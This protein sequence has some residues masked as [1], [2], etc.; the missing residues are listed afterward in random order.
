MGKNLDN[1][2]KIILIVVLVAVVGVLVY[3]S[4]SNYINP[5]LTVSQVKNGQNSYQGKVVQV[6]GIVS[7]G[8]LVRGT[9]GV[10]QF[11]L[12]D[13]QAVLN[14]VYRGSTVQNLNENREV[15]VQGIISNQGLEANQILVKC[16]SKYEEGTG[17]AESHSDWLFYAM[18]IIAI[19]AASFFVYTF[20][21]KKN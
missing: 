3:D 14:V 16:P 8:T 19:V 13:G 6:L 2:I 11:D 10:I 1:K 7:N 20:V 5:Y 4:T 12:S 9:D 18:I 21:I 15:A 17:T